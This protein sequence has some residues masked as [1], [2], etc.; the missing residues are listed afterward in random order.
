MKV[1]QRVVNVRSL[2]DVLTG[3]MNAFQEQ[4]VLELEAARAAA[5]VMVIDHVD[6]P[7]QN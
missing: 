7:Y 4:I 6:K 5:D 3:V 1:I 2:P